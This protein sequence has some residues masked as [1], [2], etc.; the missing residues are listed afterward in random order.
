MLE[1]SVDLKESARRWVLQNMPYDHLDA[2]LVAYL[3][4]LDAHGLL[5]V[6]HNWMNRLVWPQPRTVHKSRAFQQN[7]LTAQRASDLAQIIADI[8]QGRDL[9]KYLSRDIVRAPAK[10]PGAAK[11]PDLDLMLNDWGVHHLHISTHV[12]TDGFV[13]RDRSL[14]FAV[15]APH[16]AYLID[17]MMHGDWVRDHVLEVLATEWPNEGIIYEITGGNPTSPVTESQRA[18][19]RGNHYNA[20]FT[21]DGKVFMPVGFMSAAGTTMT[22][23]HGAR[24]LLRKIADFERAL[25]ANPC[26]LTPDF[27]RNGLAFPETPEFEFA[28]RE[29]GAGVLEIKTGAWINLTGDQHP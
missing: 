17:I 19:L 7:P 10:V 26:C 4:G 8:E 9:K 28:I 22:A 11:R 3:N 21:F 16:A 25:T 27:E 23:W 24:L 29:D 13:R 15:F 5:V 1:A 6:Y 18:N 2:S 20:A 14:L 12:E